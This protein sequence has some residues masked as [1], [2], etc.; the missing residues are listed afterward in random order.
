MVMT[1]TINTNLIT[2]SYPIASDVN[3]WPCP[4]DL[5]PIP[6][7]GV[8]GYRMSVKSDL[9]LISEMLGYEAKP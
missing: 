5:R 7:K 3:F 9:R 8:V 1:M 6:L 4:I 2:D